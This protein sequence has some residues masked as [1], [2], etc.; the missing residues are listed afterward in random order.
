MA[1]G[2]DWWFERLD[3]FRVGNGPTSSVIEVTGIHAD[4]SD[5]CIQIESIGARRTGMVLH[6]SAETT[7]DQAVAALEAVLAEPLIGRGVF[8]ATRA[9]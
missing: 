8:D 6:V 5:L 2:L 3:Q 4:G 9:A 7:L 1:R